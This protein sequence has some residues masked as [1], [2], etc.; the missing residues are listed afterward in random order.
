MAQFQWRWPSDSVYP[1]RGIRP[2]PLCAP[3]VPDSVAI[4]AACA[5]GIN[6]ID[7]SIIF[8]IGMAVNGKIHSFRSSST[9]SQVSPEYVIALTD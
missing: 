6:Q 4:V 7:G 3:G 1:V 5:P 9:T 8:V 2:V